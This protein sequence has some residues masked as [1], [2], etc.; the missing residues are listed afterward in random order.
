[1]ASLIRWLSDDAFLRDIF[2]QRYLRSK[3]SSPSKS[4]G[5]MKKPNPAIAGSGF[6]VS[7]FHATSSVGTTRDGTKLPA[8]EWAP[9]RWQQQQEARPERGWAEQLALGS[10][11]PERCLQELDPGLASGA[12]LHHHHRSNR[13]SGHNHDHSR[14]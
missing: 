6:L 7:D 2:G 5:S 13:A 4:L 1:V 12:L 3:Q 11:V 9:G 10:A 14:G 8:L